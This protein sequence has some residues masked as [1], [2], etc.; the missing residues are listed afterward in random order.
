[1]STMK[2]FDQVK[3]KKIFFIFIVALIIRVLY[4]WFFIDASN[5]THEDQEL[6][7]NLGKIM[8]KTGSFLQ[9]EGP[10]Y[11]ADWAISRMPGYPQFL[12]VVY[13]IFGENNMA[14]LGVQFFIDSLTCVIIGLIAESMIARGFIVAGM[15]SA[16]NLNMII[17]SG[18]ILTDTLF[19]FLFSLF[20]LFSFYYIK[21]VKKSHLFLAIF[22][23]SMSTLVRPVSYF[24][25]VI[26]LPLLIVWLLQK[27]MQLKQILYS[28]FIY[29]IPIA[30]I[31]G[32]IQYRNY[33]KYDTF[34]LVSQ[35]GSHT[36]NWVVPAVYQYSGQGSYQN[37]LS[38]AKEHFESVVD[39]K[40]LLGQSKNAFEIN[41]YQMEAAKKALFDLGLLN[42]AYAWTVGSVINLLSPSVVYAPF[43]RG[44]KHTSFYATPGHGAIEKIVNYITNTGDRDYLA[45]LISGSIISLAFI[46]LSLLGLYNMLRK[47][48]YSIRYNNMLIFSLFLIAYFLLITGPI[49]GVKYRLP[50]EPILVI[51]LTYMIYRLKDNKNN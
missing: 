3:V 37:G 38:F 6:Y 19:L 42:M 28:V 33:D 35:S 18:M 16:L 12:A 4:A 23:L 29:L 25:I 11:T 15:V 9:T 50:L 31:V 10:E 20:I 46:V 2:I 44:M 32:P 51:Y 1:M 14:I 47:N 48:V 40:E 8:A 24:L 7:I 27:R 45:I 17:L 22:F 41:S 30:I 39:K 43:V 21:R 34:L 13:G 49:V 5:L 36:L 26:I